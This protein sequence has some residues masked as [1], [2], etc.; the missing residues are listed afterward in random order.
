MN[1]AKYSH[2]RNATKTNSSKSLFETENSSVT[3]QE[4]SDTS[5][6]TFQQHQELNRKTT[7]DTMKMTRKKK[8]QKITDLDMV[9]IVQKLFIMYSPRV[10]QHFSFP[11]VKYS[12]RDV[13]ISFKTY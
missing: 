4:L 13:N 9:L 5:K 12:E 7:G 1:E 2:A 3:T 10:A 11:E 8:A 6:M